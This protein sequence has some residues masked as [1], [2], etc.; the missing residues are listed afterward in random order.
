MQNEASD[1]FTKSI[2]FCELT[3]EGMAPD[4]FHP[5]QMATSWVIDRVKESA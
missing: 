5:L 2:R 1:T 4:F 3:A